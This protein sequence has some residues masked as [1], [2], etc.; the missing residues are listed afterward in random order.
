MEP[1]QFWAMLLGSTVVGGVIT[2]LID[3]LSD[4]RTGAAAERR[5]E[6]ARAFR[7]RNRLEARTR[8]LAESLAIHRRK[9]ID[10]PCIDTD[11]PDQFPPYPDLKD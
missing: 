7:E 11:D 5:A 8:V 1:V 10:A 3:K 2:K 6:V 4:W 9:M